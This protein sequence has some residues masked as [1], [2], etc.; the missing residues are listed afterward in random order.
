MKR[1]AVAL[2]LLALMPAAA[3]AAG[4]Y[5]PGA[6]DTEIKLGNT[7]PFS[8][9][10]SSTSSVEREMAGY[11][12]MINDQG[13][14]NGR[15]I[16]FIALDD[17]YQPPKT[18]EQT[19]RLVEQD[20]VLLMYGQLGT[21]TNVAV[22][23]YLNNKKV[24]Q[25]FVTTGSSSLID[26]KK[27]PW[28]MGFQA[29]YALESTVFAKYILAEHPNARIGILYQD[30][31]FGS[32]HLDPFLATLGDKAK[33]MVVAK[34][35]YAVTDP[36]VTSQ[37]LSLKSAGVDTLYL[38][39]QSRAA[40]QAVSAARDQGGENLL[41]FLPFVATAKAVIGPVGDAKLTGVM[42]TDSAKDPSDPAWANDP[43]IKDYLAWV[44]KYIPAQD[45]E[46]DRSSALGYVSAQT[47]VEVLKRAGNDL[48]RANIMK[49]A[50]SLHNVSLPLLLPGIT[51]DT[52]P[53][54]YFPMHTMQ[55]K[56][57]DGARWQLVGKPISDQGS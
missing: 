33:T 23:P 18:V 10:A 22:R 57:Y 6:S 15:K 45:Q 54:N 20:Q 3:L 52:G 14:V 40:A 47:M 56:R 49:V 11:F 38:I 5:D 37:I 12:A 44:Q 35:S 36:T 8:G 16:N 28:T 9:P 4:T 34:A 17:G 48:T 24:P 32:D 53:D 7:W 43:A 2:S 27:Y 51:L 19:R 21:P 26:P 1:I 30:D 39:A 55:L 50:T 42:S 41:I 25:L 46:S 29:S 13:G 31:D